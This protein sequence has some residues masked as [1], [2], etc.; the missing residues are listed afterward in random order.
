MRLSEL[1]ESDISFMEEYEEKYKA[2]NVFIAIGNNLTQKG[3]EE[4]SKI[5][6][7]LTNNLDKYMT[8]TN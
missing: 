4:K 6:K 7:Y 5:Q 8:L 1:N 3:R 2:L